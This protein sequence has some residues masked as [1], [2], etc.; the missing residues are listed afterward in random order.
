MKKNKRKRKV[1]MGA[2]CKCFKYTVVQDHHYFPKRN[3]KRKEYHKR[4]I[5]LCVKCHRE[6]EDI[7]PVRKLEKLVYIQIHKLWLSGVDITVV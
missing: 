1:K 2:C 4:T 6:I 3:F 7:L 5:R